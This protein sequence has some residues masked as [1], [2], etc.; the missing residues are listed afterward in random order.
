MKKWTMILVYVAYAVAVLAIIEG[1]SKQ[2]YINGIVVSLI[3]VW[4]GNKL[5]AETENL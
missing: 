3:M 1:I 4:L 2:M 5:K